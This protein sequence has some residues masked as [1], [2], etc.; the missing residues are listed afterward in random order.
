MHLTFPL[1]VPNH[2]Q[3]KFN[4]KMQGFKRILDLNCR[5][6]K[7]KQLTFFNWFS[8]VK[9]LVRSKGSEHMRNVIEW[10]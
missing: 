8:N 7:I 3:L 2:L 1:P 6:R 5:K 9:N 4:T 10:H